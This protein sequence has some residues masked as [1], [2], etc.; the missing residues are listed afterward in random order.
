[1]PAVTRFAEAEADSVAITGGIAPPRLAPSTSAMVRP[2]DRMPAAASDRIRTTTARLEDETKA[3][4]AAKIIA[5]GQALS[6]MVRKLPSAGDWRIGSVANPSR[7]SD[8]SIKPIPTRAVPAPCCALDRPALYSITPARMSNGDSQSM[9]VATIQ[10]VTAVPTLAPSNTIWA[11]RARTSPF[12]TKD[13]I[14]SAVAV[15]L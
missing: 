3:S 11:M 15:E 4:T 10:A 6:S 5:T 7:C 12:S 13:A 9:P 8:S 1:M 14:I 2:D